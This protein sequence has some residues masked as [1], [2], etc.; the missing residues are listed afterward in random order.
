MHPRYVSYL[1]FYSTVKWGKSQW[2]NPYM[3]PILYCQYHACWCPGDLRS[4]GISRHD[5]NPQSRNILSLATEEFILLPG[6]LNKI[7]NKFFKVILTSD[8]WSMSCEIVLRWKSRHNKRFTKMWVTFTNW[9]GMQWLL[10]LPV[11]D[12]TEVTNQIEQGKD[13]SNCEQFNPQ[14]ARN[15]Q[16][17]TQRHGYLESRSLIFYWFAVVWSVSTIFIRVAGIWLTSVSMK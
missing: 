13:E 16:M 14:R 15:V 9:F 8:G 6:N 7:V 10:L 11:T 17:H 3:L 2:S 1:G 4:Q 5:I 12:I